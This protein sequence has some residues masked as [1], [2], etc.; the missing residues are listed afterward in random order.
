MF[1]ALKERFESVFS[2]LRGRGKLTADDVGAALREVRRALLEADVNYKVV[3]DLVDAIKQRATGAD[4]LNSIT[5]AQQVATIVYDEMINI[6]GRAPAPMTISPKPPTVYMMVGLQGSGKTTTSVKLAKR[7]SK[8]HRPLVVACDLRRPAAVDQLRVLAEKAGVAFFGPEQGENDPVA[9]ARKSLAYAEDHLCDLILLDTAGRL[10]LDD[11]LMAELETMK[12]DVPPFE[13]LLVVDSMTGQEAVEVAAA[14][15]GRLGLT[16]VVLTKMDGDA[17]GGPALAIK[18]VT[19]VPVKLA[20]MGERAEDLE[21][22]D[23][24]RMASRIMGMGDMMGLMEKLEQ[25]TTDADAERIAESFRKS[26]FTMEDMLIQLQQVKK[27]GPLD[28]VLEMLPIPGG[29]K[30]FKGAD[31]D[32][33][34]LKYFEAIIL[35][36]TKKERRSPDIIKGSRRRR[37]AEGS[38]TSV[39]LVNQLLAQYEQMKTMM[40]SL[41]KMNPKS[42]KVAGALKNLFKG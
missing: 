2:S 25:S 6:M 19:G 30:A 40:K 20:G 8:S 1:E 14:F 21:V 32:M 27:L 10:Q 22:F 28:K 31:M 41:G 16:G 38:G 42:F 39:Q 3:K 13:I 12:R 7:M 18:A 4:V 24:K 26:K 5:P 9:V 37:I 36:M 15:N 35:S 11:G 33:S 23:S 34:R 29:A 17:R